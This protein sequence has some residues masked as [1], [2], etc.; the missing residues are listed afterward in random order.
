MEKRMTPY[1]CLLA[2]LVLVS[3]LS[4]CKKAI[5]D[6]LRDNPTAEYGFC[7]LKQF[8][9]QLPTSGTAGTLPIAYDTMVFTYNAHGDPVTGFRPVP[10]TGNP[11]FILRYDRWDRLTDLI[12]TYGTNPDLSGGIESWNRYTYDGQGRIVLDSVYNFP[13]IVDGHPGLGEHSSIVIATYEYDPK[14]RVSKYS[15]GFVGDLNKFVSTYS[16]DADGNLVGTPHDNQINLHRTNK[17]WMFM[18]RDYSVNN[19]LT[20]AY[21]YNTRGLP[22]TIVPTAGTEMDFF[23]SLQYEKADVK[24]TCK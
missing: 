23:N 15:W 12:G 9:Y 20:A 18:D 17:V 22:V 1:V 3:G 11:N 19:P 24:Y 2:G 21:T 4:G 8:N 7:Q 13:T 10:R 14:N 6:Y 5:E 16:Y